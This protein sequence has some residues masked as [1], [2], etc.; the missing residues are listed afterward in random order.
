MRRGS[1]GIGTLIALVAGLLLLWFVAVP[2]LQ[3]IWRGA[4]SAYVCE[5]DCLAACPDGYRRDYRG[6]V[7]CADLDGA[8]GGRC[9]APLSVAP[10]SF[11]RG[12]DIRLASGS[13]EVRHGGSVELQPRTVNGGLG[14]G[15]TFAFSFDG[16]VEENSCYWRVQGPEGVVEVPGSR[17][18]AAAWDY[19]RVHV[20]TARPLEKGGLGDCDNPA[21]ARSELELP[22]EEFLKLRG[23][24]LLFTLVVVDTESCPEEPL[25]FCES[26][27]HQVRVEVPE[28]ETRISVTLDGKAV[29]DRAP[30]LLDPERRPRIE[31]AIEEQL[32]ACS[33]APTLAVGQG[34]GEEGA[35]TPPFLEP[36]AKSDDACLSSRPWRHAASL[37]LGEVARAIPFQVAVATSVGEDAVR[38]TYRFQVAPEERF[39][40][41]GPSPGLAP[42]KRFDLQCVGVECASFAAAYVRDPMF[43]R[44][45]GIDEEAFEEIEGLQTYGSEEESRWRYLLRDEERNGRYACLRAETNEG[46]LYSLGLHQGLPHRIQVDAT[47]PTLTLH[48]NILQSFTSI[49]TLDCDDPKSKGPD[50]ESDAYTSGCRQR[51]YSYAYV[52]DPLLFLPS[53][54]S[55]GRLAE[56]WGACP[57]PETGH[58]LA[59]NSDDEQLVYRERGAQVI[60]VRAT[61]NAGNHAVGAKLLYSGQEL[62]ALLM[63]EALEELTDDK[64]SCE[65]GESWEECRARGGG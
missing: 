27:E 15:E 40:V 38:E 58:W 60:C 19:Y 3:N 55:G 10:A 25:P 46:R 16:V 44:A 1:I 29:S 52:T 50:G 42:E 57:D 64:V 65:P 51:P 30:I 28:R 36:L 8:P 22:Q 20:G 17:S 23:E 62:L 21:F 54:V 6:D 32:L 26:H 37:D 34:L 41:L 43:C 48:F 11:V 33:V 59:Y 39:R 4:Q 18:L 14:V 9:C 35:G 63:S 24:E 49:L 45:G 56:T 2:I 5:G 47:P 53:V 31:V 12:G 13:G 61:D 7:Y